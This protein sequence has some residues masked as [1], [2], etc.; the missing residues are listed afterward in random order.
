MK[1]RYMFGTLG[2]RQQH[3][4]VTEALFSAF[5]AKVTSTGGAMFI[6]LIT[7]TVLWNVLPFIDVAGLY[8]FPLSLMFSVCFLWCLSLLPYIYA[9]I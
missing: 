3:F 2:K 7:L 5:Q 6:A 4:L 1:M 8:Y 9:L